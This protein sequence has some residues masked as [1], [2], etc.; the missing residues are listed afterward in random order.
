[1]RCESLPAQLRTR[2]QRGETLDGVAER[3]V[4]EIEVDNISFGEARRI[5]EVYSALLNRLEFEQKSSALI[6]LGTAVTVFFEEFRGQRDSWLNWPTRIGLRLAA[7][8]G[9]EADRATP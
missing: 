6:N 7:G 2:H 9:L 4:G 8:L 1:M 3:L 5:K